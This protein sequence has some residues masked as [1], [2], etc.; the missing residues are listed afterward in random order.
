MSSDYIFSRSNTPYF[1]PDPFQYSTRAGVWQRGGKNPRGDDV[2]AVPRQ[3]RDI[4]AEEKVALVG[5]LGL[6]AHRITDEMGSTFIIIPH[7]NTQTPAATTP[8]P[9]DAIDPAT[10]RD[11]TA[12]APGPRY[13]TT[14]LFTFRGPIAPSYNARDRTA[15]GSYPDTTAQVY[16]TSNP[17]V[18]GSNYRGLT[19]L[20]SNSWTPPV[21]PKHPLPRLGPNSLDPNVPVSTTRDPGNRVS[22]P[23]GMAT[24]LSTFRGPI[25]PHYNTWDSTVAESTP[26][27]LTASNYNPWNPTEGV[28]NQNITA[29]TSGTAPGS[30]GRDPVRSNL[31]PRTPTPLYLGSNHRDLTALHPDTRPPPIP[32]KLPLSPLSPNRW[33][34]TIPV[35]ISRDP[36]NIVPGPRDT[37][38]PLS[39]F[40]G[41]IPQSYNTW[42]P[43]AA[44]PTQDLTASG[45][46]AWDR[47]GEVSHQDNTAQASITSLDSNRR[48][49]ALSELPSRAPAPLG[50]NRRDLAAL[51]SD[52]QCPPTSTRLLHT[53]LGHNRWDPAPVSTARDPSNLVSGPRDITAPLPT[54]LD[55]TA[56]GYGA[57]GHTPATSNP[58]G[59]STSGYNPWGPAEAVFNQDNASQVSITAPDKGRRVSAPLKLFSRAPAPLSHNRTALSSDTQYSRTPLS[60]N[61]WYHAPISTTRDPTHLLSGPRDTTSPL[62]TSRGPTAPGYNAR[63]TA[64]AASTPQGHITQ[65]HNVQDPIAALPTSWYSIAPAHNAQYSIPEL[66]TL[67]RGTAAVLNSR[68][69]TAIGYNTW[70]PNATVSSRDATTPISTSQS[71]IASAKNRRGSPSLGFPFLAPTHPNHNST[72]ST[73]P[74]Y[75][76]PV[77]TTQS[78]FI[79]DSSPRY[80]SLKFPPQVPTYSGCNS[81]YPTGRLSPSQG[82]TTPDYNTPGYNTSGYNTPDPITPMP[83]TWYPITPGDNAQDTTTT[84][85]SNRDT[86][87]TVPTS[88]GPIPPS[89]NN[90]DP[91]IEVPNQSTIAPVSTSRSPTSSGNSFQGPTSPELPPQAPTARVLAPQDRDSHARNSPNVTATVAA[92]LD[93]T[94]SGRSARGPI[95]PVS[96]RDLIASLFTRR[97]STATSH[98]AL[99]ISVLALASPESGPLGSITPVSPQD[100]TAPVLA[101]QNSA[102]LVFPQD[103]VLA[104]AP[105]GPTVPGGN[106]WDPAVP[107]PTSRDSSTPVSSAPVHTA[108]GSDGTVGMSKIGSGSENDS[109]DQDNAR[110]GVRLN[111]GLTVSTPGDSP[112]IPMTTET[113]TSSTGNTIGD[114]AG[115]AKTGSPTKNG[116]TAALAPGY[117]SQSP[118][119]PE[120]STPVLDSSSQNCNTQ[121]SSAAELIQNPTEIEGLEELQDGQVEER[122]FINISMHKGKENQSEEGQEVPERAVGTVGEDIEGAVLHTKEAAIPMATGTP[123]TS[124]EDT[125]DSAETCNQ[126]KNGEITA[127]ALDRDGQSPTAP[128]IPT[129]ASDPPS[130]GCNTQDSNATE[131]T[132]NP[133]GLEGIEDGQVGKRMVM[134]ISMNEGKENQVVERQ[135][136]SER[137]EEILDEN[138][139]DIVSH[140]QKGAMPMTPAASIKDTTNSEVCSPI[141]SGAIAAPALGHDSQSPT[142]SSIPVRVSDPSSSSYNTQDSNIP[143]STQNSAALGHINQDPTAPSSLTRVR[144]PLA[145]DI[146]DHTA[147]DHVTQDPTD[148]VPNPQFPIAPVSPTQ[149][150]SPSGHD[151]HIPT[152]Q[153]S[154]TLDCNTPVSSTLVSTSPPTG[155]GYNS[156]EPT[157]PEPSQDSSLLE[158][159]NLVPTP[160]DPTSPVPAHSDPTN[161]SLVTE[162]LYGLKVLFDGN[163]PAFEYVL[164]VSRSYVIQVLG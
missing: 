8:Y 137:V 41:S 154:T 163:D 151:T 95:T 45:Y 56:L 53:P 40:R 101:R 54:F 4:S 23:Q 76:T 124:T 128:A 73:T 144:N 106:H 11:S 47:T 3:P 70:D 36:S 155:S 38:T 87:T 22:G 37:V 111:S 91:S 118:T 121:D 9:L 59:L 17:T 46:S 127:L 94:A 103:F 48:V 133:A 102:S 93:F 69:R 100:L 12:P 30:N 34:P 55:S 90:Q 5:M 135:E 81:P 63:E 116:E 162:E 99:G 146:Q 21:P 157:T 18:P 16:T 28:S 145:C 72:D 130:P 80:S 138:M 96:A 153:D 49:S 78:S 58:Q 43:T 7:L 161:G 140:A 85:I 104:L 159:S 74:G 32:L 10:V 89:Y 24:P 125:T 82:P 66:E 31:S 109:E 52:T 6:Q 84:E 92:S 35:A 129:R 142:T 75:N 164:G 68:G 20:R 110:C 15:A 147:V 25:A 97:E 107:V 117:D 64:I 150:T 2:V 62:P 77:S 65:D 42:D 44:A 149:G 29:Q 98:D 114:S 83:T 143:G 119:L 139:E 1:P 51:R 79:S 19:A 148:L 88:R 57:W 122:T 39:T 152:H 134:N 120:T 33:D 61:H 60:H 50:R 113:P 26:R 132:R 67:N 13:T 71:Y 160:E 136:M 14:P 123:A 112:A 105:A 141:E 131:P 156:Q 115:P 27:G 126:I 86:T 108:P 158:S